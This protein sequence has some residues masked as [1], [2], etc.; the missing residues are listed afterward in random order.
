M[1]DITRTTTVL[2]DGLRDGG[3][4]EAWTEFDRRYRPIV[5]GFARR[6][7]LG[8]ADAAD[9]AQETMT[10]FLEEYGQ[11]KYHRERGRLRSWLIG[12]AKYR[13]AQVYRGRSG[14]REV[15]G[16]SALADL[17]DEQRLTRLW[18]DERRESLLRTAM[19]TLRETTKTDEKTIRAFELL[20][21]NQ[22]APASVAEQL[23]MST[24]DVYRAKNRVADRLRTIIDGLD[25]AYEDR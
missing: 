9:V 23:D 13:V 12:L 5:M 24:A 16:A 14:R 15:G 6:L 11:G 17:E 3:N 10:R 22:V 2:L 7:G 19:H 25:A 1:I 8:D 20:V 21:V 4:D 18:E